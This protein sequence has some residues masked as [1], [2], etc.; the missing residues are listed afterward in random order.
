MAELELEGG[1]SKIPIFDLI[2]CVDREL[3]YRQRVYPR[4]VAARKMSQD[5][6]DVEIKRMEM[7]R[8]QLVLIPE[9][10]DKIAMV[11]Q[12]NDDLEDEKTDLEVKV[13]EQ[14]DTLSGL[15]DA[16]DTL[17]RQ[18]ERANPNELG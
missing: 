15:R 14:D 1:S 16:V 10:L 6:A 9:L 3:G 5:K 12:A 7:V 4:W 11:T 8:S 2:A 18:L 13:A 17:E